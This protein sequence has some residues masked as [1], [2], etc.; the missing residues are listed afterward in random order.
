MTLYNNASHLPEALESLLAQTYADFDLVLLDDA[1]TDGTEG[2]ARAYVERDPRIRYYRHEARRAMIATWRDV[3]DR[4]AADCPT[5]T[6]FAWV[7]DHDRW[8][9]RWLERLVR[10]LDAD[11]GAVLAYPVTR[12]MS[13]AGVELDKIPRRFD[14]A[15]C[16]D[17]QSRWRRFCSNAIGHGDMVYGLM[18]LS[19][20]RRAGVFREVLRPDRLLMAE[21]T[22]QGRIRQ[23]PETLWFRRQ[24]SDASIA[25]QQSSLVLHGREPRWFTWPPWFQHALVLWREY[26]GRR[27]ASPRLTRLRWLGM[28]ARYQVMYVWR[29]VRKSE[30]SQAFDRGVKHAIRR[31]RPFR[32]AAQYVHSWARRVGRFLEWLPRLIV[33]PARR[34]LRYTFVRPVIL[35]AH[36][37]RPKVRQIGRRAER[38]TVVAQRF[39]N[40]VLR[41]GRRLGRRV[42]V[43]PVRWVIRRAR[44]A[45]YSVLTWRKRAGDEAR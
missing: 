30:T 38:A 35:A 21:L 8:H 10:E 28:L 44:L 7:S 29:H 14:T 27:S 4:A 20:L 16:P 24:S 5:A 42:A 40:R 17:L 11:E 43:R 19:A 1:S 22:L 18:R 32:N 3:V 45:V 26:A 15:D 25:R 12:L 34:A 41:E 36:R 13:D 2:V 39:S 9:P 31:T 37:A 33:R 6:Y 23:V